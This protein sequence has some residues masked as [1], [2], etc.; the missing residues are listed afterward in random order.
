MGDI[1]YAISVLILLF[2]GIRLMANG[3]NLMISEPYRKPLGPIHPEMAD[4]PDGE[5]LMVINFEE[6]EID[7]LH[8]SLQDR[9]NKLKDDDDD[10][11][12]SLVPA[13]R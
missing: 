10:D 6:E 8:A 5:E 1:L 12:G 4:V 11:G 9:I 7:P 3:L 2:F 13:V